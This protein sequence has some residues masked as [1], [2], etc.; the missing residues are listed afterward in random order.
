MRRLSLGSSALKGTGLGVEHEQAY[1]GAE[2][3]DQVLKHGRKPFIIIVCCASIS[4][5]GH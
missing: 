5:S 3:M 1:N 4:H 2:S